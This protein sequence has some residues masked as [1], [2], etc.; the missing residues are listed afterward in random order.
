M[1]PP[2]ALMLVIESATFPGFVGLLKDSRWLQYKALSTQPLESLIPSIYT[3]I[4]ET[5]GEK[6]LEAVDSIIYATG[7]GSTLGL[8]LAE[9]FVRTLQTLRPSLRLYP[10]NTLVL[11]ALL[12]A[13]PHHILCPR[14]DH[15]WQVLTQEGPLST[16]SLKIETLESS[17]LSA[18][19]H[20]LYHLP[21]RK[22]HPHLPP[23]AQPVELSLPL[24]PTVFSNALLY[25]TRLECAPEA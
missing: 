5:L 7:P 21:L 4:Q 12:L 25:Q 16:D 14:P 24:P 6:G 20:T 15:R 18:L 9:M 10:Y 1:P 8:R 22:R 13:S 23:R 19:P 17:Q 11:Y 3:C 2:S